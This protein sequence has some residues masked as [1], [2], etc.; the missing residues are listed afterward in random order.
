[1]YKYLQYQLWRDEAISM[2]LR[3]KTVF[4]T[5]VEEWIVGYEVR[6]GKLNTFEDQFLF[7]ATF[8][9]K[10]AGDIFQKVVL[11]DEVYEDLLELIAEPFWKAQELPLNLHPAF[12][13][14]SIVSLLSLLPTLTYPHNLTLPSTP[15]PQ[16]HYLLSLI[17]GN[18]QHYNHFMLCSLNFVLL[19]EGLTATEQTEI[20]K[21]A[22]MFLERSMIEEADI[23]SV[24][25]KLMMKTDKAV[26]FALINEYVAFYGWVEKA[27]LDQ[28]L[29][30]VDDMVYFRE[31]IIGRNQ[32]D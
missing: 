27:G 32:I 26:R 21:I 12:P 2:E 17:G 25:R 15:H 4:F 20:T 19:G 24:I 29:E 30:A 23:L 13:H 3:E 31:L 22:L 7:L 28:V 6:V 16:P 10:E 9:E 14:S 11:L 5:I 8:L 18:L 1:M